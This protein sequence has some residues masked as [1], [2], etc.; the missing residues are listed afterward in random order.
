MSSRSRWTEDAPALLRGLKALTRRRLVVLAVLFFGPAALDLGV[1]AWRRAGL[2][3]HGGAEV[4]DRSLC[5]MLQYTGCNNLKSMPVKEEMSTW[6]TVFTLAWIA[7]RV[8]THR[9]EFEV[10]VM[11][12]TY[13]RRGETAFRRH[14]PQLLFV[15]LWQLSPP[16]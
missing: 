3:V 4:Q 10:I 11:S 2:Q 1:G 14:A 9:P 15:S 6:S 16:R 13:Q 7:V 8:S 5:V 12:S